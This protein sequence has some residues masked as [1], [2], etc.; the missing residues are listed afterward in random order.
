MGPGH[1]APQGDAV[2]LFFGS[3]PLME[4]KT[5]P[6]TRLTGKSGII[7]KRQTWKWGWTYTVI[8]H[9]A[10]AVSVRLEE[11][12]PQIGDEGV[13]VT[14]EDSPPAQR[15]EDHTLYWD[16]QTPANGKV[17]VRHG[18]SI[19]APEGLDIFPGR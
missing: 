13:S 14:L 12:A 6:D 5:E 9:R 15:G 3:D 2:T 17:Q 8:N 4:V 19:S 11:P 10:Q 16:V 18:V 7:N 1:F